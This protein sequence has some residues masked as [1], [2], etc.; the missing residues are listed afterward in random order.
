MAKVKKRFYVVREDRDELV[1]ALEA[2]SGAKNGDVI[3]LSKDV[4][5]E[6]VAGRNY[7]IREE[8]EIENESTEIE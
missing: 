8:I 7:I 1:K 4:F 5:E 6:L 3:E 2:L